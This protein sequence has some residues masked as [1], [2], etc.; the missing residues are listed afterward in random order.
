MGASSILSEIAAGLGLSLA[1]AARR[2][3]SAR[4]G[5]PV[6]PSCLWRWIARGIILPDGRCVRLE[7]ARLADRWLTSEPAIERFVARQTPQTD[8]EPMSAPRA[9]TQRR[10]ASEQAARQLDEIG[11]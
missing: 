8:T 10:R 3:P 5:R 1:Q 7:A 4:Q 2:L 6:S 11:I 9:P